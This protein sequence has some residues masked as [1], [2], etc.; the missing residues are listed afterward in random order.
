[1]LCTLL[2]CVA[3]CSKKDAPPATAQGAAQLFFDQLHQGKLAPAF[4]STAF[5]FQEQ[6]DLKFFTER[7]REYELQE[8]TVA[9][10]P[11]PGDATDAKTA[12]FDVAVTM[13]NGQKYALNLTMQ[14]EKNAW[15]VYA[16]REP[17][18]PNTG[19][20][21]NRFSNVGGPAAISYGA[22]KK[23]PDDATVR[24][25]VHNSMI[26]FSDAVQ[27]ESFW[28]F[29][30]YASVAWQKELTEQKLSNA[31]HS[32]IERKVNMSGILEMQPILDQ[33]PEIGTDGYLVVTGHYPTKPYEVHFTLRYIYELPEWKLLGL[34]CHLKK[35][36]E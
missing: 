21:K 16:L 29:Y 13:K 19:V 25:L 15:R 5:N 22:I 20:G 8:S 33:P 30:E 9:L 28:E 12:K 2:G 36:E 27:T 10:T 6:Q 18:N 26:L 34:N 32:F 3:A 23:V 31:F 17:R 4:E 35:V 1:M 14:Q 24:R 7:V 11:L